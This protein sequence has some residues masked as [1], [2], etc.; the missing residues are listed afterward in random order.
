MSETDLPP[1]ERS[2][3]A[4]PTGQLDWPTYRPSQPRAS[5]RLIVL[6]ALALVAAAAIVASHAITSNLSG[7]A[8][9]A[10]P[11]LVDISVTL[12]LQESG[13][14][15]TGMVLTATGE[16]LTNNHVIEGATVIRGDRHRQ[17]QD[18]LGKCRGLRPS[19]TT[20]LSFSSRVQVAFRRCR[21]ATHPCCASGLA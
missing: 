17:R 1:G 21:S 6:F 20:W 14:E 3:A 19:G 7:I 11:G 5:R 2:R 16:G 9:R 15:A 18:L 12:G 13:A 8:A 10:D 4:G